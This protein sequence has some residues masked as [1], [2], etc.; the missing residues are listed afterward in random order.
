MGISFIRQWLNQDFYSSA[1]SSEERETILL[2][3]L[4]NEDKKSTKDNIFL[5]SIQEINTLNIDRA[6]INCVPT[7]YAIAQGAS[8]STGYGE[9]WTRTLMA[10]KEKGKRISKAAVL[11]SMGRR[12]YED[13]I[14]QT[15]VIRPALYIKLR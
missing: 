13:I 4:I 11:G 10:S 9:W 8:H 14:K 2:T 12:Y 15:K 7:Q 5:L 1:F 3:E 6:L